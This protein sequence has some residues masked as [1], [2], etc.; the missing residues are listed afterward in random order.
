MEYHSAIKRKEI[1]PFATTGME[2]EGTM[3]KRN[4]SEKETDTV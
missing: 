4:R 2:V 1:L 3:L